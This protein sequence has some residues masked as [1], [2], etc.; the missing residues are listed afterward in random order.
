MSEWVS[1]KDG[2]PPDHTT[3]LVFIRENSGITYIGTSSLNPTKTGFY[4]AY[5]DEGNAPVEEVT[6]W[7]PLP[8]P[9]KQIK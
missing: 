3:Y 2:L 7:M 8:E 1:V 4:V 9:P 6:H 5:D